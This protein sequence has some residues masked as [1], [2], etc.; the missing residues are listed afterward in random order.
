MK[1][2]KLNL[3]LDLSNLIKDSHFYKV[4]IGYDKK[5][6]LLVINKKEHEEREVYNHDMYIIQN[7]SILLHI[8]I[9][10]LLSKY[11]IVQPYGIDKILLVKPRTFKDDN[12]AK[13]YNYNGELLHQFNLGDGIEKTIVTD[14]G[15]IWTSYFD[16]GVF[17]S[18][19]GKNGLIKWTEKGKP[20][21]KYNGK[22]DYRID[23]CY[24]L[25]ISN[26]I[27]WFYAYDKFMV[28]RI[29]DNKLSYFDCNIR[30]ANFL[31]NH[32]NFILMNGGYNNRN[33]LIL[34]KFYNSKLVVHQ[35]F[36]LI[37]KENEV[38]KMDCLDYLES[39]IVIVHK[40]NLYLF[41]LEEY[42]K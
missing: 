33:E 8:E 24:A 15:E 42:I 39:C 17:G 29:N 36:Q 26:N 40:S 31:I 30:G 13:I 22:G 27:T 32:N 2:I 1:Q 41:C 5:M 25:N 20:I 7:K 19:I 35:T 6:Y 3:L 38:I 10:N 16:E 18:T 23:D 34:L 21:Y 9:H 12:N 28:T 14:K 4:Y 11:T 37:D